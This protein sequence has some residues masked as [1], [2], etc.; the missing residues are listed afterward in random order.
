MKTAFS[1][2]PERI[3][4]KAL[5]YLDF[6]WLHSLSLKRLK[7]NH[8]DI[9]IGGYCLTPSRTGCCVLSVLI[10]HAPDQV[11]K[12]R[13]EKI[14]VLGARWSVKRNARDTGPVLADFHRHMFSLTI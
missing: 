14:G 11:R 6:D 1:K 2:S 4:D 3:A 12:I 13:S 5:G 9:R 10:T 7:V 8:K